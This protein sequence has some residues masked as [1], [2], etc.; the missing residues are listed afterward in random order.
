MELAMSDKYFDPNEKFEKQS[1]NPHDYID[2]KLLD[3]LYYTSNASE[4]YVGPQHAICGLMGYSLC[5]SGYYLYKQLKI[6]LKHRINDIRIEKDDDDTEIDYDYKQ[7]LMNVYHSVVFGYASWN[8][9]VYCLLYVRQIKEKR[10]D[11][12]GYAHMSSGKGIYGIDFGML[13]AFWSGIIAY[14]LVLNVSKI[15]NWNSKLKVSKTPNLHNTDS[16]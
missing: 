16:K 14:P 15:W 9:Y 1:Y 3:K 4:P 11:P 6:F 5:L 12:G 10:H 13:T 2:D 7:I 8:L